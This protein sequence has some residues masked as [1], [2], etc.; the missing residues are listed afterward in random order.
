MD[1]TL[2]V[3]HSLMQRINL[4]ELEMRVKLFLIM[5]M[6]V[7]T[8]LAYAGTEGYEYVRSEDIQLLDINVDNVSYDFSGNATVPFDLSGSNANV[9]LAIYTT[10]QA[11]PGGWGGPGHE[12]WNGGHALLRR[13]G[14]PN[15]VKVIECGQY[16]VGAGT[17]VWD[18]TDFAGD[19]V[20]SGTY[21]VYVLAVDNISDANWVAVTGYGFRMRSTEVK[22][23]QGQGY[24]YGIPAGLGGGRQGGEGEGPRGHIDNPYGA[25]FMLYPLA[26]GN[27]LEADSPYDLIAN[28]VTELPEYGLTNEDGTK[29][30]ILGGSAHGTTIDP[31]DFSRNWMYSY[32]DQGIIGVSIDWDSQ[33]S[34]PM[35]GFGEAPNSWTKKVAQG[36]HVNFFFS[37]QYYEG[38]LYLGNG[39]LNDPPA[40]GVYEVDSAS[41]EVTDIIDISDYW[42]F[43]QYADNPEPVKAASM[44]NCISIDKAGLVMVS[45]GWGPGSTAKVPLKVDWN[46]ELI[47]MNDLGDGFNDNVWAGEAQAMGVEVS[48]D[49]ESHAISQSVEGFTFVTTASKGDMSQQPSYGAIYGPDGAGIFKVTAD[50][51]PL[52]VHEATGSGTNMIH[53]HSAWD[54]L[55]ILTGESGFNEEHGGYQIGH[56]PFRIESALIGTDFSTAVEEVASDVTPEDYTLGDAYPN[57]FNPATT[58]EFTL[59]TGSHAQVTVLNSQGQQVS[60]LVNEF[61]SAGNYKTSWN[62]KIASGDIA[63]AGLYFYRLQVGD[64]VLTKKMTLVK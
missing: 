28:N 16:D 24:M 46:G 42:V 62:G 29:A 51:M 19:D 63:A 53:E 60:T 59:P 17:C 12:A 38:F 18:G 55:Y 45:G 37:I 48:T 50:R 21:R 13:E 52:S 44:I 22:V 20:A 36:D 58:I 2:K 1:C 27:F 5:M 35:A 7:S 30:H 33:T 64:Q 11:T 31:D 9:Y 61:L 8:S 32:A 26:P 23:M 15:M 10:N 56:L 49:G 40:A 25:G 34:E 47:Y 54:G 41:G 6:V 4:Q 14:I 57:P 39:W 3:Y 43:D